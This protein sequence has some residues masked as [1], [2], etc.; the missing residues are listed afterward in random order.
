MPYPVHDTS[1][2]EGP[3]DPSATN[4]AHAYALAMV[5]HGKRVLEL[6]CTGGHFTRA[7]AAQGCRVVGVELDPEAARRA[8]AVAEQVLEVDLDR[9]GALA[10]LEP[11]QFDAVVAGDVLEHLR[12]PLATLRQCR[13]LLRPGGVLVASIP[14]VAHAD[15]RLTLLEGSF[16]YR[17]SGLLDVTH[18]RFFTRQTVT[19]LLRSAGLAPVEFK[20]VR[21]PVFGTELGVDPDRVPQS[22]LERVLE[23]PEAE[24]YQFVVKA[25]VDDG[26]WEVANL[27][28]RLEEL[29]GE[30]QGL[31]AQVRAL[32]RQLGAARAGEASA[33][34]EL[35][36]A[37]ADAEGL[38]TEAARAGQ[39]AAEA[40]GQAREA[41]Q[42]LEA[43]QRTRLFRYSSPLR[44][45]YAQVRAMRPGS[46]QP[47][48]R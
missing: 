19:D 20:R 21:V 46:A 42:Q 23:D 7:L 29:D 48:G 36:A 30:L 4:N 10:A 35:E 26:G 45:L 31:A 32:E 8:R 47:G 44:R 37:R 14:N 9:P 41:R 33:R 18:L 5:G 11:A 39:R 13:R 16:P 25:V 43:L 28:R 2:Y 12:D 40:E 1:A 6:G 17:E 22:V 15:V 3:V 27:S 24:T 38:R 34:A